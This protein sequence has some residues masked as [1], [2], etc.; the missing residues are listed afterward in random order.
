MKSAVVVIG[1]GVGGWPVLTLF[2]TVPL[3]YLYPCPRTELR[4]AR[5]H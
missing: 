4:G 3:S 2:V 5:C 1:V